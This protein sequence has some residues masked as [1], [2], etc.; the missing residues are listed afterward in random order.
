MASLKELK[1]RIHS[2]K[3]T[4][5]ITESMQLIS[6]N[7]LRR[8]QE[9]INNASL[10]QSR[11]KEF[12]MQ[13]IADHPDQGFFSPFIKG[14]GRDN[15]YLLVVCTSEKGLCGGFN[16]QIIRFARDRIREFIQDNKKIKIFIIGRKGY[17]GLYAEFSSMIIDNIELSSK[18]EIDFV[19]AGGIAH[20]IMSLFTSDVFDQCFFIHSEFKSIMQQIP[21]MSK[22]IPLSLDQR[23]KDQQEE[24]MLVYRYEPTH[25]SVI[26]KIVLQSIS[27]QIFWIILENKASELGAR[28]TAM[29]NATRNAG[30]M[31]DTL[32]LS[33]NRQRQ[34][35]ITTELI[36]IIAGAEAV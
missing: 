33:Y 7:K 36:E 1:N 24:N 17:E 6:V 23:S 31:V 32:V 14:T 13:C 34:M 19:K 25:H 3:E 18:K 20:Q 29:D 28:V 10:Y 35:R 30:Q 15:V 4:Q 8:V 5:K 16:S 12:F 2:V 21:R 22:I 26:E 11:I 9:S 27:S